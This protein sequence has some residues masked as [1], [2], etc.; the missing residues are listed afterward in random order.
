MALAHDA[1]TRWP[2]SGGD[3]TTGDRTFTHTP[4]GTPGGVVVLVAGTET[5][6]APLCTGVLYGGVAMT[7]VDSASD[8]VETPDSRGEIYVLTSGIP[9]GAQTVT[10]QGATADDK[11]ATCATLTSGLGATN[12]N[13]SGS[14]DTT[15][16][17]TPTINLVTSV[18]TLIYGVACSG[19][20][21]PTLT[22][23][24]GCT[25]MHNHDVGNQTM[26]T[27]RRTSPDG[28]G[29][30]TF[31]FQAGTEDWCIAAVAFAED[32]PPSTF[33]PRIM[34]LT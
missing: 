19:E 33:V 16:G 22:A 7:F 12:I 1:D 32:S 10:I 11:F 5:A 8:T 17:G 14:I 20:N 18:T 25:L 6:G 28:A 13:T 34:V 21:S 26:Y 30:I 2:S 29:T 4:A 27:G 24:T 9:T 23:Q 31:G 3:T 15:G